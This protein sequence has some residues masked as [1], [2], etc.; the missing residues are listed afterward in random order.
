MNSSRDLLTT[1]VIGLVL[2]VGLGVA[3]AGLIVRLGKGRPDDVCS[4]DC[5]GR[6]YDGGAFDRDLQRCVCFTTTGATHKELDEMS[7]ERFKTP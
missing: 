2:G 5:A 1:G 4:I 3:L 7:E 6:D